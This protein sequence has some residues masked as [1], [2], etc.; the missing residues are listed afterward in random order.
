MLQL[1]QSE[2]AAGGEAPAAMNNP[3][4]EMSSPSQ[5]QTPSDQVLTLRTRAR[6]NSISSP[7]ETLSRSADESQSNPPSNSRQG[8]PPSPD[9]VPALHAIMLPRLT[10]RDK[11]QRDPDS[12]LTSKDVTSQWISLKTQ[13][14]L[15]STL[16]GGKPPLNTIPG[17][18]PQRHIRSAPPGA[19][20]SIIAACR[21]SSRERLSWNSS[22]TISTPPPH[23]P[24]RPGRS[25]C[26]SGL[27]QVPENEHMTHQNEVLSILNRLSGMNPFK[28]FIF[29][30]TYSD[31]RPVLLE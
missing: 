16:S 8:R 2:Q 29:C 21:D 26:P 13:V 7:G 17:R 22:P 30:G 19:S 1:Q 20:R 24:S 9:K 4:T 10:F 14:S 3:A 5:M 18:V 31:D 6:F 15:T 23:P 11:F 12:G 28:V 27:M 25:S